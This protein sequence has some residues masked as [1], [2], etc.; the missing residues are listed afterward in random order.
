M[1]DMHLK[2]LRI[3]NFKSM[4]DL[5]LQCK[6]INLFIGEP[7]SG[8]SNI[9]EAIGLLSHIPQGELSQFVRYEIMTDLFY[10]HVLDEA[11]T[12]N[13][14]GKMVKVE[15][16][17]GRFRGT[18]LPTGAGGQEI[19]NYDY[20]GIGSHTF[21]SDFRA[22][23]F[24]RFLKQTNFRNQKSDFLQPPNGNNLLAILMSQKK[25]KNVVRELFGSFGYRILFRP[26]E[27]KIEVTKEI[28]DVLLAIPYSL[29]SETLQ[30]LVFYLA[31]IHSNR[32][33]IVTFEEPE[34]HAFPYYT[35]YLA[36][37]IAINENNNQYLIATHNPYFLTSILEKSPKEE[38]AIFAT[39][40][41][42]YQTKVSPLTD[43]QKAE[44]LE[45]GSDVFFNI[46]KFIG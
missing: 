36:E 38:V 2:S 29:V 13:F 22:F 20:T 39:S 34:A 32:D 45:L 25:L 44:I 19:F 35:K 8:K 7:N 23:K 33:S 11:I 28:E 3:R 4:K 9:L 1:R 27:A 30:R 10:D 21:L 18:Y 24:Y 41:K 46:K 16:R 43:E 6:K 15:F 5:R 42:D 37:R 31:A 12:I 40:L 14:D 17:D 26:E